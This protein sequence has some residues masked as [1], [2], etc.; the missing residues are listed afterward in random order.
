MNSTAC[1]LNSILQPSCATILKTQRL[2]M[3][4]DFIDCELKVNRLQ[5]AMSVAI[6]AIL[7]AL[8][9]FCIYSTSFEL[10]ST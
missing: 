4:K 6:P 2:L 8:R 10:Q 7:R 9:Y 3:K 5:L 1:F